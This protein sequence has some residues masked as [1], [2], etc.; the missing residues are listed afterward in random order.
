M[1]NPKQLLLERLG[2]VVEWGF[3]GRDGQG[4]VELAP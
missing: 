4:R 3:R 1:S 2:R